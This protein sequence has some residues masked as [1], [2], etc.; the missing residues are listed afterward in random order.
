MTEPAQS[1]AVWKFAIMFQIGMIVMGAFL[2]VLFAIGG[3]VGTGI[4]GV[5]LIGLA[6]AGIVFSRRSLREQRK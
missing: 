3:P 4:F 2:V 5:V 6:I 1:E